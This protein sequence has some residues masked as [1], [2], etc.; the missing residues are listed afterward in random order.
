MQKNRFKTS[1]A[2]NIFRSKYAQGQNDTWD[3]LCERVVEDVCGTRW[4]KDR[5]L[6]SQDE[7]DQLC[8]Y[9]KDFK[10]L[11][12]GRY[13]WY[14]GRQ[15][16]YFNNCASGNTKLLTDI[17]WVRLKDVSGQKVNLFSPIEKTWLPATV[18]S[19]GKQEIYKYIV[20]PTYGK[21]SYTLTFTQDHRWPTINRGTVSDLS[22]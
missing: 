9:M 2:E 6:M 3:A 20:K 5:A 22:V 10:F 18:H 16:S 12:G 19:H 21:R 4:G 8:K 7:R 11:A 13:L 1:F 14:A 17:G 15:N